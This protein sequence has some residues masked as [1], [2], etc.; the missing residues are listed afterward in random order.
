ME[1]FTTT[2]KLK[3]VILTTRDI[4]YVYHRW[5]G[6]HQYNTQILAT[7][8][9][10]WVHRYSSLLQWSVPL[11]QR[12]HMVLT[13]GESFA[14]SAQNVRCTVTTDLLVWYSNTQNDLSPRAAIFSLHTLTL[15][16]GRNVNYDEKQISGGKIFWVVPSICTVS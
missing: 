16:S 11:G 2:G 13:V 7:H 14:Y 10:T 8:A 15:L 5:H 3:K 1:L 4:Q 9:S 6:T 12:G